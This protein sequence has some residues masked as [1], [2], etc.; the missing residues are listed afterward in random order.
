MANRLLFTANKGAPPEHPKHTHAGAPP[1]GPAQ[2]WAGSTTPA[3]TTYSG[4]P[5]PGT[6]GYMHA[7]PQSRGR[8]GRGDLFK[9]AHERASAPIML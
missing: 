3:D 9:I 4:G 2:P 7:A 5:P 8:L 1:P 6:P